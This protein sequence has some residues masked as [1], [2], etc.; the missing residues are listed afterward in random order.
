MSNRKRIPFW[1]RFLAEQV[2]VELFHQYVW[3]FLKSLALGV[4][5]LIKAAVAWL[6]CYWAAAK[7]A[8]GFKAAAAACAKAVAVCAFA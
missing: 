2:G 1:L 8:T 5:A 4:W 7:T 6:K 3:P